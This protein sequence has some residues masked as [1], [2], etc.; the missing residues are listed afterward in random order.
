MKKIFEPVKMNHLTLNN[1]LMRS[2]TWEGISNEDGSL[3]SFGYEIYEK[4]AQGGIGGIIT[5]FTS[6]M[7]EDHYFNAMMRLSRDDLIPQ[8]QNLTSLIHAHQIPVLPQ[9]ALGAYYE[10]G[11]EIDIDALQIEQIHHIRQSFIEA[12]IRAKKANFDGVQLHMAH[13]FFLS[14]FVSPACNHRNDEYGG[15]L[16]NR[17]RLVLEIIQGIH[18]EVPNFHIGIK[19]NSSDFFEGGI[20]H[21]QALEIGKLLDQEGIDSIEVSGN[22]TSMPGIRPGINEGYFAPFGKDLAQIVKTPI[23]VVGGLRSVYEME[24]ILNGSKIEVLSLSRPLIR[25]PDLPNKFKEKKTNVAKC[26]SCNLCYRSPYHQC[27]FWKSDLEKEG[28]NQ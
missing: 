7:D 27:V 15:S 4:L 17:M 16:E 23:M 11:Q 5:G 2:A 26:I 24:S 21:A 19:I 25:E 18:Q 8:Y 9:L 14:R 13:F 3:T 10:K 1:R 12:A 22:G 6:V 28:K 20:D